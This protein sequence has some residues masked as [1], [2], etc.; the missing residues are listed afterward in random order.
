MI[1]GMRSFVTTIDLALSSKIKKDLSDQGFEITVPPYTLFTAKKPGVSCTLY[2]SGKL[3]VQGKKMEEFIMNYLETEILTTLAYSY[4][5]MTVNLTPHMG[6]DESGKGDYF[7][8]LCIAGVYADEKGIKTLIHTLKVK[9]S[10]RMSDQMIL[11]TAKSI[12]QSFAYTQ[13]KISPSR[14]NELYESFKNLNRLLSWAHSQAISNLAESTKC[15][16]AIVDQF[17]HASVLERSLKL[18]KDLHVQV[19]QKVRAEED[20][21]VAAASI[22]AREMVLTAFEELKQEFGIPIPKGAS[23]KVVQIGQRLYQQYGKEMFSKIAKLHFSTTQ[24]IFLN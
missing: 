14:Y 18:K 12:K 7:G 1:G 2:T 13:V 23:D 15:S 5:E 17:A 24:Q 11:N 8:P 21:V 20:P 3:M 16:L 6:F 10:K 22:L 19:E 9:D 4:P